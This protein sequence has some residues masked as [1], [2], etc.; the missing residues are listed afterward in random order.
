MRLRMH[1]F[2]SPIRN[3]FAEA[4][5]GEAKEHPTEAVA[6]PRELAEKILELADLTERQKRLAET[7]AEAARKAGV[8]AAK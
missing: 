8:L 7:V 4:P 6:V 5:E 1:A 3:V 2:M